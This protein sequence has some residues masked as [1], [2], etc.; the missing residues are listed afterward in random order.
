MKRVISILLALVMTLS[1]CSAAWAIE[2]AVGAT[3]PTEGTCGAESNEGGRGSVT[4]KVTKNGGKVAEKDENGNETGVILPAYTLTISGKGDI[5]D[6][7]G[8]AS[9]GNWA[10]R[11][12]NG[13][14]YGSQITQV[15]VKEGIT[16]IGDVAFNRNLH[17]STISIPASVTK[18]G[19]RAFGAE[20]I[21]T[22][23]EGNTFFVME[24]NVLFTSDKKTLVRYFPSGETV[25]SYT[26]PASVETI[27]GGAFQNAKFNRIDLGSVKTIGEYAFQGAEIPE[28]VLPE[29]VTEIELQLVNSAKVQK[30]VLNMNMA[31][32]PINWLYGANVE[33]V[34]IGKHITKLD[35]TF[36]NSNI[37]K[38][39]FAAD[40]NVKEFVGGT[41]YG[42][43]YLESI[44][45]PDSVEKMG[46]GVF[47]FCTNLKSVVIGA[48]I[49]VIPN[50]AFNGCTAL[51]E[52]KF[53]PGSQL[54][55]VDYPHP[56]T[57]C[58]SLKSI[59][60]PD[61]CTTV[62]G[63]GFHKCDSLRTIVGNGLTAFGNTQGTNDG[64]FKATVKNGSVLN[65][66]LRTDKMDANG[67]VLAPYNG[68][69]ALGWYTQGGV[70]G[71]K[72]SINGTSTTVYAVYK[73]D[74]SFD[75]N[76]GT[77]DVTA[78]KSYVAPGLDD[79]EEIVNL[80]QE[81]VKIPDTTPTRDGYTFT[82]WNTAVDG[83]GDSYQPR[84]YLETTNQPITKLYAQW[85]KEVNGVVY[86][87]SCD[88]SLV[89]NGEKQTPTVTVKANGEALP[90]DQY[91]VAP[92]EDGINA[93]IY[94]GTVTLTKVV[95]G[96]EATGNAAI[97]PAPVVVDDAAA[98]ADANVAADADEDTNANADAEV[99][100]NVDTETENET[101]NDVPAKAEGE[102]G[103][104][105]PAL[106]PSMSSA[107]VTLDNGAAGTPVVMANNV[108]IDFKYEI[109]KVP[110][111]LQIDAPATAKGNSTV[112]L[113]V[114]DAVVAPTVTCSDTSIEIVNNNDGT[115]SADVPDSNKIY[116][117]TVTDAG[118]ANH[119]GGTKSVTVKVTMRSSST[120]TLEKS[121]LTAKKGKTQTIAYTYHGDGK[122]TAESS[123]P[124]VATVT[125]DENAKTI[126]VKLL[127][128]GTAD[129]VVRAAGTADY[130]SATA[131]L[132][133]TVEAGAEDNNNG[134]DDNN[135][136]NNNNSNG[137]HVNRRY[138]SKT[139]TANGTDTANTGKNVKSGDTGDMGIALYAAAALLSATGMAWFGKKRGQ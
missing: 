55:T 76:G 96:D 66:I 110:S 81:E 106:K 39:I 74:C 5:M 77:G 84:Q 35:N 49:K 47:R 133:L 7:P 13:K 80:P 138:P 21:V 54:E 19:K 112:T 108:T 73:A 111:T 137:G 30:L 122:V 4:W 68:F 102:N 10:A 23:A 37:K 36:K 82:G 127:K 94:T 75:V 58:K 63:F 117:F 92:D 67:I 113:T 43:K 34:V 129:I 93:G 62:K 116:T 31:E 100:A 18:I 64:F 29:S 20:M 83:S 124:S 15:I 121:T 95:T 40:S 24:D 51:E 16:G 70:K 132:V 104:A 115:Y 2:T 9:A 27:I 98:A 38:V 139:N 28:I 26:V 123:D 6:E 25:N 44:V 14:G 8:Q 48:G 107:P 53:A 125:M 119:E 33:E 126:T 88:Q 22:L 78:I 69:A 87:V 86:T 65:G 11:D 99:D 136:N 89:F 130:K 135:N 131:V 1:L 79:D 60:L 101:E 41:F 59:E 97:D 61:S 45:I 128:K 103:D 42:M 90:T 71:D 56:F 114:S 120:L 85:G 32:M 12:E 118:D 91:T 109:K 134:N 17:R 52:V 46:N 105:A 3:G 72:N 57:D 50:S